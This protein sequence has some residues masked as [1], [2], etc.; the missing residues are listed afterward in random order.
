MCCRRIISSGD[1]DLSHAIM[2]PIAVIYIHI[3]RIY[4]ILLI[5]IVKLENDQI[6]LRVAQNVLSIYCYNIRTT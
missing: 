1:G 2:R 4:V 6:A 5:Y 3:I